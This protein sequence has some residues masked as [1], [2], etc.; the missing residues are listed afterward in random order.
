MLIRKEMKALLIGK[1]SL[2]AKKVNRVIR[3]FSAALPR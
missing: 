2:R 1:E 3:A